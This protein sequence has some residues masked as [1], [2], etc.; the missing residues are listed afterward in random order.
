MSIDCQIFTSGSGQVDLV[1]YDNWRQPVSPTCFVYY[2]DG[3]FLASGDSKCSPADG[4]VDLGDIR[5]T[6]ASGIDQPRNSHADG[7]ERNHRGSEKAHVK[8]VGGGCDDGCNNKDDKNGISQIP[9]HPARR[10]N[11]HQGQKEN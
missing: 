5:S 11:P 4:S 3:S 1:S 10:Y 6:S 2:S 9:P 8:D 7:V